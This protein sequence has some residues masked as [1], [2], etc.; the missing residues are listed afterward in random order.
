[1]IMSKEQ[2]DKGRKALAAMTEA[3]KDEMIKAIMINKRLVCFSKV[4]TKE[5]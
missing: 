3:E 1:M 2:A 4:I 5:D